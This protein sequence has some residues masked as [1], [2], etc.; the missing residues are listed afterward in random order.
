MHENRRR[1]F[2]EDVVVYLT[3]GEPYT[4]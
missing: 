4:V 3:A 2:A 1:T